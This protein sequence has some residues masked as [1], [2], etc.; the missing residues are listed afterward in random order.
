MGHHPYPQAVLANVLNPKAAAV[1]LTLA[2]QF[3]TAR[4]VGVAPLLLLA[5][6]RVLTMAGWLFT[7]TAVLSRARRIASSS[8]FRTWVNRTGGTVL[9]ALGVRTAV[10]AV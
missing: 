6:V 3:L 8:K 1:C 9:I 4:D 7:W 2:P 10:T 5:T